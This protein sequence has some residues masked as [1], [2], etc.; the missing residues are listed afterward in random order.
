MSGRERRKKKNEISR[1][2]VKIQEAPLLKSVLLG[3][4]CGR[5][6]DDDDDDVC[7]VCTRATCCN[8]ALPTTVLRGAYVT[9]SNLVCAASRA[10]HCTRAPQRRYTN[11]TPYFYN[12]II[13]IRV[14]IPLP[15]TTFGTRSC[16]LS[17]SNKKKRNVY[18]V[19]TSHPTAR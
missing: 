1:N 6:D 4:C 2:G 16:R 11:T 5:H 17:G 19:I 3:C 15:T 12:N 9:V 18:N 8:T 14:R 10:R 13:R 7:F